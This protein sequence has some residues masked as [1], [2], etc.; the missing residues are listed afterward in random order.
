MEQPVIILIC[1]KYHTM[2]ECAFINHIGYLFSPPINE[3]LPLLA[4]F[5]K[6]IHNE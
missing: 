4:K 5:Q 6:G 3:Y 1:Y 2:S